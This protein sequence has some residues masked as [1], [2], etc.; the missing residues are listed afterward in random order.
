M[1]RIFVIHGWEGH[2]DEVWFPWLKTELENRGHKVELLQMPGTESPKIDEWVPYLAQSVGNADDKT[3][4]VGHSMGCQTILRY[5]ETLPADV[6][7]GGAVLV[8][9]FFHLTGVTKPDEV[10][11]VWPW[12]NTPIDFDKVKSHTDKFTAIF[13]DNDAFVPL[14]NVKL[15]Q[16]NLGA[17][18]I[19]EHDMNHFNN[20]NNP[21]YKQI[22]LILK[23][24]LKIAE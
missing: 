8:A 12:I 16:Q 9:G 2:P 24:F 18:T 19:V 10:L 23:S 6:R 3:Y 15:F 22:P 21:D 7:V 5:L 13:S 1:K 14:T 20:K 4:F 11:M 17:K